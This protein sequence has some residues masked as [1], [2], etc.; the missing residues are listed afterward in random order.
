M[1]SVTCNYVAVGPAN[2]G[3]GSI[4][5]KDCNPPVS[6]DETMSYGTVIGV[7]AL[8]L[9]ASLLIHWFLGHYVNRKALANIREDFKHV[10]AHAAELRRREKE[11][12]P[13]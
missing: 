8:L 2:Q 11:V 6:N 10:A 4:T 12:E 13:T 9:I 1:T 7:V 3:T 5:L